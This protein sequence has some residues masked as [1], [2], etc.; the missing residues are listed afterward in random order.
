MSVLIC[1]RVES[2]FI[3][4][5]GTFSST[6][7]ICY[8]GNY[9]DVSDSKFCMFSLFFFCGVVNSCGEIIMCVVYAVSCVVIS[10]IPTIGY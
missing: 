9:S 5:I 1:R 4:G 10:L 3:L 7:P 8:V 2:S 6:L